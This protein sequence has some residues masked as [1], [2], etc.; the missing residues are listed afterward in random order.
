MRLC[1]AVVR[2]NGADVIIFDAD[3]V[4][5]TFSTSA[6]ADID[7]LCFRSHGPDGDDH[8][9]A[10]TPCFDERG[11]HG[12]P[13]QSCPCGVDT[14]HLHAHVRDPKTCEDDRAHHP[15][16][17]A[18]KIAYLTSQILHPTTEN[19]GVHESTPLLLHIPVTERMPN[20][21]NNDEITATAGTGW[22]HR[23]GNRRVHQIQH[24]G[25]V[26]YLVHNAET[27]QMHLEH[28][29]DGCGK[30]DVHGTFAHLGKRRV[31]S[32]VQL[33]F[34][35]VAPRPFSLR[36]C[37]T[38]L[39]ELGSDRVN[40]VDNI[41]LHAEQ[42]CQ[43]HDHQHHHAPAPIV[44]AMAVPA[45]VN[46]VRSTFKCT[47]ICC[48][49]EIPMIH[50]VLKPVNGIDNI[51][52]NVP[53]K[54]VLIDHDP[55]IVA[56]AELQQALL[57]FGCTVTRD[58]GLAVAP[59]R[60]AGRSQFFVQNIC[61]ASE[62]PAIL[63]IVEPLVGV[64]AVTI[65]T[66]V[67]T[68]Y[69][70]H[71][72]DAVTAAYI[73]AALNAERFGAA[74]RVD[75]G[76][77]RS[78][79]PS[80]IMVESTLR[81]TND[82]PADAA[83]LTLLLQGLVDASLLENFAVDGLSQTVTLVHNP[84]KLTADHVA[85]KVSEQSPLSP[86]TVVLDGADPARWTY[87]YELQQEDEVD[88]FPVDEGFT[89]PRPT[90]I[91]SGLLWIISML[92]LIGGRWYVAP[93]LHT[94]GLFMATRQVSPFSIISF[95]SR[96]SPSQGIFEVGSTGICRLWNSPDSDESLPHAAALPV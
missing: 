21:C 69:V 31:S 30:H 44:A 84:F 35:T 94:N 43:G 92:S 52:I 66:T 82:V 1:L 59:R 22:R 33:H 28:A 63:R 88:E 19:Y 95:A 83:A 93:K 96:F 26:D 25:H 87:P 12:A 46:V 67:K 80:A 5:R 56:A 55:S 62:I 11:K 41:M 45:A 51:R 85:A 57:Q 61:C 38:D 72:V 64:K 7:Q 34:F 10:L 3:G 14:P 15:A 48:A 75:A 23:R 6:H 53:L 16:A 74:T 50:T 65:N 13:E 37:L 9:G 71:D 68:V 70:D 49:S 77:A 47:Q 40:A 86:A 42:S 24:G 76:A 73:C 58:G 60:P 17:S 29:C 81:V 39:F 27:D 18:D 91:I 89:L 54:Q 36:D 32:S 79:T 90:V 8:G 2:E 78:K 4:P 20:H